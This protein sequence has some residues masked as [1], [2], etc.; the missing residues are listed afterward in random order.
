MNISLQDAKAEKKNKY[1]FERCLI[2]WTASGAAAHRIIIIIKKKVKK[3]RER[4]KSI[5]INDCPLS[6]TEFMSEA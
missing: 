2:F 6:Q 1:I 5:L 4:R 3:Q